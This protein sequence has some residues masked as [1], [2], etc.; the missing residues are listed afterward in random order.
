MNKSELKQAL[1]NFDSRCGAQLK[2]FLVMSVFPEA[3]ESEVA[4]LSGINASNKSLVFKALKEKDLPL[5]KFNNTSNLTS[6][7]QPNTA[8]IE[9]LQARI[10]ELDGLR[11]E[12]WNQLQTQ[13]DRT[14]ALKKENFNLT[15]QVEELQGKLTA[16]ALQIENLTKKDSGL[17]K[18]EVDAQFFQMMQTESELRN[19]VAQL[20]KERDDQK[21]NAQVQKG[22]ADKYKKDQESAA[23][24]KNPLLYG[25]D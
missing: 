9:Q 3:D 19:Q 8:E 23:R 4:N 16:A 15:Q 14:D 2:A 17:S 7:S 22:A 6:E 1:S 12:N 25:F 24:T 18:E 21:A 5:L 20:T 11:K 13:V 10:T